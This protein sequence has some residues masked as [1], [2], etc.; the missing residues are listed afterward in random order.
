MSGGRGLSHFIRIHCEV[1]TP[2]TT[3]RRNGRHPGGCGPLALGQEPRDLVGVLRLQ[4]PPHPPP[5]TAKSD[6]LKYKPPGVSP[7]YCQICPQKGPKLDLGTQKA[8]NSGTVTYLIM[9]FKKLFLFVSWDHT[10]L[11]LSPGSALGNHS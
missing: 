7:E 1:G 10:W 5:S 9:T 6:L 2:F 3:P 8:P 4:G 11:M